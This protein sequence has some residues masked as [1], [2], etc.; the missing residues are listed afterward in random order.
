MGESTWDPDAKT[1]LDAVCTDLPFFIRGQAKSATVEKAEELV[2]A[3]GKVTRERVVEAMIAITPA[4]MK[5]QLKAL[6]EKRGVDLAR[7]SKD[8]K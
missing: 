2:G 5:P 3:G 7:W 1:F 8:L 4:P 6:L